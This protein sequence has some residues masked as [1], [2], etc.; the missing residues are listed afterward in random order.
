MSKRDIALGRLHARTGETNP[1]HAILY[2]L[3]PGSPAAARA[4]EQSGDG[5][6][7]QIAVCA[8]KPAYTL[9]EIAG[10]IAERHRSI[11][12]GD[13]RN[14][15]RYAFDIIAEKLREGYR[16]TLKDCATFCVSVRGRANPD[17]PLE[18]RDA[19]VRAHCTLAAAF[20]RLVNE[21]ARL[22]PE[23]GGQ[24]TTVEI[25]GTEAH[26]GVIFVDGSFHGADRIA[27]EVECPDGE[28][29]AC[30]VTLERP[31]DSTRPIGYTLTI[32]PERPL[33]VGCAVLLLSW[34]DASG[35]PRTR[36]LP[37]T[38]TQPDAPGTSPA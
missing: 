18:V 30:A 6:T 34:S 10:L 26:P 28:R 29:L 36:C 15:L 3:I 7:A 38:V 12:A 13:A 11:D 27:A 16:V 35:L 33:A 32:R 37:V 24:P 2:R 17:R 23:G 25:S 31:A 14:T 5:C 1:R 20:E 19:A 9:D 22:A 8:K 21:G 4:A